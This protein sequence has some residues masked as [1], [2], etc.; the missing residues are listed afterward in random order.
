MARPVTVTLCSMQWLGWTRAPQ[1]ISRPSRW[2]YGR[3]IA[4]KVLNDVDNIIVGAVDDAIP[5]MWPVDQAPYTRL[6]VSGT[7]FY[8]SH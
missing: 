6:R 8:I 3:F 5:D 2:L 4:C 7:P 1:S